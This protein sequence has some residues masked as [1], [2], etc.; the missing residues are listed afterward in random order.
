MNF[1]LDSRNSG[2]LLLKMTQE[3]R[4]FYSSLLETAG[5]GPTGKLDGKLAASFLKKSGLPKDILKRIWLIASPSETAS[6]DKEEFYISLRLVA[7]A[8]NNMEIS[9][10]AI[11]L[12]HP[13]PPL[14][15]FKLN[16]QPVPSQSQ[17]PS[18]PYNMNMNSTSPIP[19]QPMSNTINPIQSYQPLQDNQN[20]FMP[21]SYQG[22]PIDDQK[23]NQNTFGTPDYNNTEFNRNQVKPDEIESKLL[24]DFGMKPVIHSQRKNILGNFSGVSNVGLGQGMKD[25]LEQFKILYNQEEELNKYLTKEIEFHM[26]NMSNAFDDIEKIKKIIDGIN[27]RKQAIKQ[28]MNEYRRKINIENDNMARMQVEIKGFQEDSKL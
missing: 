10:E 25:M 18:N 24:K 20:N 9:E 13:I 23:M 22:T 2:R 12:N 17:I 4:G 15:T 28:E 11:R 8:Q 27:M 19:M 7:L 21:N 14:P 3:E 6:M 5:A 1:G 26:E 16:T